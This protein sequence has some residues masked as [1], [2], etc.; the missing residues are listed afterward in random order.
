MIDGSAPGVDTFPHT[1]VSREASHAISRS[2][3]AALVTAARSQGGYAITS[4]GRCGTR[5]ASTP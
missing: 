5:C 3:I 4:R 2:E 1:L